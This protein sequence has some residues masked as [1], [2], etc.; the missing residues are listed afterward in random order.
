MC[1]CTVTLGWWSSTVQCS[2]HSESVLKA[3]APYVSL[4]LQKD[5]S[6]HSWR[7]DLPGKFN[8][9][10]EKCQELC[11][12]CRWC[13][14][15]ERAAAQTTALL[16]R[17]PLGSVANGCYRMVILKC[18]EL[19]V[20]NSSFSFPFCFDSLN[21]ASNS[22]AAHSRG[23]SLSLCPFRAFVFV[24]VILPGSVATQHSSERSCCGI[25]GGDTVDVL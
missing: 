21:G 20:P 11:G 12:M 18:P 10:P 8:F 9:R 16:W 17:C 15:E 25:T 6:L 22:W 4:D 2:L 13:L 24:Y 7:T 19:Q 23:G 5:C 14:C 3:V 1:L